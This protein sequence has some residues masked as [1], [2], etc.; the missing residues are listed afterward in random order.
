MS[1]LLNTLKYHKIKAPIW[2]G[3]LLSHIPFEIFSQ[4]G[5]LICKVSGAQCPHRWLNAGL[6]VLWVHGWIL[7]PGLELGQDILSFLSIRRNSQHL[8]QQLLIST[9]TAIFLQSVKL[10]K[11]F[12]AFFNNPAYKQHFIDLST[13]RIQGQVDSV[14][15]YAF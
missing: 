6:F 9:A 7:C 10:C 1:R 3:K 5:T 13:N 15:K 11:C 8:E 14:V 4:S 12:R 2:V